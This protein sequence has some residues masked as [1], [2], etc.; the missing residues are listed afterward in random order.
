[1]EELWRHMA[2]ITR[3]H[4]YGDKWRSFPSDYREWRFQMRIARADTGVEEGSWLWKRS[5]AEIK[6]A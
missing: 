2:E 5:Y 4:K 3:V 1:V 6:Q